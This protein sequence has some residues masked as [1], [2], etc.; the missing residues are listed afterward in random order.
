MWSRTQS[1]SFS[2]AYNRVA[3]QKNDAELWAWR[4]I[5]Y[6]GAA[7]G[8]AR[9][10][11]DDPI[12]ARGVERAGSRCI[13]QV[14]FSQ[15]NQRRANPK[16][17]TCVDCLVDAALETTLLRPGSTTTG[18]GETENQKRRIVA[19]PAQRLQST[20]AVCVNVLGVCTCTIFNTERKSTCFPTL[21]ASVRIAVSK[22]VSTSIDES[23][24]SRY[25]LTAQRRPDLHTLQMLH[26]SINITP[27]KCYYVVPKTSL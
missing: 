12:L 25:R 9:P 13:H 10:L 14:K 17:T 6:S 11:T 1:K 16:R 15:Q 4:D 8:L 3:A 7:S 22:M 24:A 18:G 21:L 23:N 27:S 26:R 20:L 5:A 19:C 2:L